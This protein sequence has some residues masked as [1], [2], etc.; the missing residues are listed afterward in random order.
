M[1]KN[2]NNRPFVQKAGYGG[3]STETLKATIWNPPEQKSAPAPEVDLSSIKAELKEARQQVKDLSD[4]LA[5]MERTYEDLLYNLD[6]DNLEPNTRKP[7][8]STISEV[9]PNGLKADSSIVQSAKEIRTEVRQVYA[10]KE[11]TGN[12]EPGNRDRNYIWKNTTTNTYYV[13]SDLRGRWIETDTNEL[14]TAFIQTA[15]GFKFDA[16]LVKI[17]GDLIVGGEITG[18]V[19]NVNTDA[20]VGKTLVLKD[21]DTAGGTISIYNGSS[22][23]FSILSKNNR[24]VFISNGTSSIHLNGATTYITSNLVE[25]NGKE[26]AVKDD[27]DALWVAIRN[28]QGGI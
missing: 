27:I 23:T 12:S 6:F 4:K 1:F 19:I 15:D 21:G 3:P 26:V 20:T 7:I 16:D 13:Y 25:I 8:E 2:Q 18:V 10:I 5:R 14:K 22:P 9:Y 17:S 24:P 11:Y 28:L